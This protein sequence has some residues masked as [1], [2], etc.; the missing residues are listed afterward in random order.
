MN[1]DRDRWHPAVTAMIYGAVVVSVVML[2]I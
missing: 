2:M 1:R